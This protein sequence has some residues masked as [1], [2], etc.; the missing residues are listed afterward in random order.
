MTWQ[1]TAEH[2]RVAEANRR[3][4]AKTAERYDASETC[5]VDPRKQRE[6]GRDMERI[7]LLAKRAWRDMRILD[8]CAGSGNATRRFLEAGGH[9]TA[10][11]ISPEL[12]AILREKTQAH[13]ERLHAICGDVGRF[14]AEAEERFD[15]IAFSSALHHFADPA[16]ILETA[17]RCLASGGL[18]YTVFDPTPRAELGPAARLALGADYAAFKILRQTDDVPGAAR[19][20]LLRLAGR[21]RWGGQRDGLA[22]E[23]LGLVAERHAKTGIDDRRLVEALVGSGFELVWHERRTSSRFRAVGLALALLRAKTEFSLLL[24]RPDQYV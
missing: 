17:A 2:E 14:L 3:Y 4:Y 18:L 24:R 8:A 9:V 5:V 13:A 7:V 10:V 19:R 20:R 11:D 22:D 6:L 1:P 23:E 21:L 16:A 12:L 15:L